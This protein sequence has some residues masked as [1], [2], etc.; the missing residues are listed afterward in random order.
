MSITSIEFTGRTRVT[1]ADEQTARPR[2]EVPRLQELRVQEPRV[3]DKEHSIQ[4]LRIPEI[5][6][7]TYIQRHFANDLVVSD[8]SRPIIESCGHNGK[9]TAGLLC[10]FPLTER[11]YD[12]FRN[13]IGQTL[14]L[15]HI[16]TREKWQVELQAMFDKNE[17]RGLMKHRP[18]APVILNGELMAQGC[19]LRFLKTI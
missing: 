4:E 13:R 18:M 3:Q 7:V 2:L 11:Q 14:S 10:A 19:K 6:N 1:F 8:L 9:F 12:K 5:R 17:W 16:Y 15:S